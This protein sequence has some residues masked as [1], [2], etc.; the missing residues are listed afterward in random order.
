MR[1]LLGFLSGLIFGLGLIVSGMA[2]PAKVLNFLDLAG[3]WDPSL[4]FV[5]GGA[6]VVTFLGYRLAWQQGA[7]ILAPDFDVPT[8]SR[9]DR[10]LILGAALFGLGWGIGGFCPG[11]AW[12]A[13]P[14]LSPGILTFLPMMLLGLWLGAGGRNL[15]L[16]ISKGVRK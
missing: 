13:L 5:M 6:V 12:T 9:I 1:N 14:L 7:P 8:S 10:P 15:P 3:H 16:L 11:P 4:G 2:N